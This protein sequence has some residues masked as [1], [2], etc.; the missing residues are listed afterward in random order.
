MKKLL[1]IVALLLLAGCSMPLVVPAK[2][3]EGTFIRVKIDGKKGSVLGVYCNPQY[4]QY[5]I[6]VAG[7]EESTGLLGGEVS[8]DP[9]PEVFLREF[10][11]EELSK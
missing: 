10:E 1:P 5:K 6:R 9:Y 7:N 4:C 3:Q 11:I 2:F 8:S